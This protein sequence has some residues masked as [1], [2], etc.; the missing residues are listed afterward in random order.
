VKITETRRRIWTVVLASALAV[1]LLGPTVAT[2]VAVTRMSPTLGPRAGESAADFGWPEPSDEA[3]RLHRT[4]AVA[5][6]HGDALLWDRSLLRRGRVGHLD[7]ERMIEGR[8]AL[9]AFSTVTKAPF[10]LNIESNSADSDLV[11]LVAVLQGWP[12]RTWTSLLQRALHQAH[13]LRAAAASSGGRLVVVETREDLQDFLR[14]RAAGGADDGSSPLPVAAGFLAIEGAHA[15]EGELTNVDR[16][17]DAGFRMIGLTHFFDNEVGGSAH[18]ID[19]DG[20]TPFGH[21]V[22]RRMEELGIAVDLAHASLPVIDHVL[23]IAT[24][25]IIVSHTGVKGTCDNRRNYG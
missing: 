20:L 18:G 19:K 16:V 5:D 22:V 14:A 9:Q 17:F 7:L 21:N 10:G 4:L 11:R 24:A 13:K 15:L 3:V 23:G 8:I 6:L 25:P 1:V 2:R 12:P